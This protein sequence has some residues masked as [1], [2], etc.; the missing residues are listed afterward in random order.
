MPMHDKPEGFPFGLV[1]APLL[2]AA[3][4]HQC[5]YMLWLLSLPVGIC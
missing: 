1:H 4:L 2:V 5:G 3:A